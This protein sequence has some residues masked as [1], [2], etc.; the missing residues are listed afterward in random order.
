V[1]LLIAAVYVPPLAN[2]LAVVRPGLDGWAL[3]LGMSLIPLALGQASKYV[4]IGN[5]A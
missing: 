3:V 2:V 4:N 5:G 1:L